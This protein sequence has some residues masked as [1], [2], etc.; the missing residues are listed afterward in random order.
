MADCNLVTENLQ[1]P[2]TGNICLNPDL[3][4][5]TRTKRLISVQ[6]H[7][8]NQYPCRLTAR[9]Q[10]S[11]VQTA[12]SSTSLLFFVFS[13]SDLAGFYRIV[14]RL[15]LVHGPLQWGPEALTGASW[16]L[17][18]GQRRGTRGKRLLGVT[19]LQSG[20]TPFPTSCSSN[21]RCVHLHGSTANGNS[22]AHIDLRGTQR[23]DTYNLAEREG[24]YSTD[25]HAP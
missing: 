8:R 9:R 7:L 11:S 10:S 6:L 4:L 19:P 20:D 13:Q 15:V 21:R 5:R 22:D 12:S 2:W 3:S 25:A 23:S 24:V 1:A 14:E 17:Q 18:K 16:R